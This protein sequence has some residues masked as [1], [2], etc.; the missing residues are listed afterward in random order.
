MQFGYA[1]RSEEEQ[2]N[3]AMRKRLLELVG[4]DRFVFM[5]VRSKEFGRSNYL[6]MR[7]MLRAGDVLYVDGL[8]SLGKDFTDI[9]QEWQELTQNVGVDI[10]V[11]ESDGELDSRKFRDLGAVGQQLEEQMLYLLHYMGTLQA[12]ERADEE[13]AL[14]QKIGRPILDWDWNLFDA[15]AQ[16]WADGEIE[17][18]EACDIMDSARSS[19]YKYAKARGFKRKT[20]RQRDRENAA[21]ALEREL[22]EKS[23]ENKKVNRN[24]KG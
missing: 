5:D 12:R 7:N 4:D 19:W 10:V 6:F 24:T 3:G 11:L 13:P 18:E 20:K 21:K 15:T 17:L 22:T 23:E 8:D 16:R 9:A 2:Q 1:R 14:P